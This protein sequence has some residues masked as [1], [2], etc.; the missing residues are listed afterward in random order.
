MKKYKK[1]IILFNL[2]FLIVFFNWMIFKKERTLSE[3]KLVLL[4]LAP[5]DPRSLMQGD[6]MRLTYA[7]YRLPENH[8]H[9]KGYCVVKLDTNN[10]AQKVR[11]QKSEFPLNDGEMLI[12]YKSSDNWSFRIGVESYFF[13][14]GKAKKFQ[15]AKYGALRVDEE[16]NAI[17]VG[18]YNAKFEF[19]QP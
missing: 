18:L 4:E 7:I 11:L 13:E 3:G 12:K 17:I 8:I 2:L 19:I 1:H 14:E 9:P 6:F 5:V 15:N 16:G 10:V